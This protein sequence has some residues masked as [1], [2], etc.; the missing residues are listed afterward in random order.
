[1]NEP[2]TTTTTAAAAGITN[3]VQ[4]NSFL[5]A[6]IASFDYKALSFVE[7]CFHFSVSNSLQLD[8]IDY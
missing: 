8:H 7:I 1:M 3:S 2:T 6:D 5:E 4:P